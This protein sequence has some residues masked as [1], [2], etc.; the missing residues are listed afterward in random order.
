MSVP[1][2]RIHFL[3]LKAAG[4][5]EPF[6][7]KIKWQKAPTLGPI[8]RICKDKG[9]IQKLNLNQ[10][11]NIGWAKYSIMDEANTQPQI[12]LTLIKEKSVPCQLLYSDVHLACI[13]LAPINSSCLIVGL[14][15]QIQKPN[16]TKW[17][18]VV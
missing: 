11:F 14:P 5:T 8:L 15:I 18:P 17:N 12:Q 1:N 13:F 6:R 16:Q 3:I 7:F 9:T 2:H 10:I 4:K